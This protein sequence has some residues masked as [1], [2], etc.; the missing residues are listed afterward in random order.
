MSE[1]LALLGQLGF[2]VV[3]QIYRAYGQAGFVAIA[4]S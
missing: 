2:A 4:P 3:E 1:H